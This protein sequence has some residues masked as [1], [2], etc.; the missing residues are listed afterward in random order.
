[1]SKVWYMSI[2]PKCAWFK[3]AGKCRFCETEMIQ[4]ETTFD[5]SMKLKLGSKERE[6]LID[7][8][9]ETLIK[10]TYDPEARKYREA[11]ENVNP[12]AGYVQKDELSCP[13]CHSTNVK[14]I[15]GL[16]KAGSVALWGVLA[17]GKVS[18]QWHCNS[19]GSDF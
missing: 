4:T 2:C 3:F 17:A 5:E 9:I 19:C 12:F 18:K 10:D 14:K 13:Y 6:E 1:M 15:S 8:Y 11:N 16:S 7:H